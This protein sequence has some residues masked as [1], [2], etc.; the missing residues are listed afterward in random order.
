[1]RGT[2][3]LADEDEKS[4]NALAKKVEPVAEF[5]GIWPLHLLDLDDPEQIDLVYRMLL[6]L[7]IVLYRD[8]FL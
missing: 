1:M 6:Y 2:K 4:A 7:L 8:L 5:D 3:L